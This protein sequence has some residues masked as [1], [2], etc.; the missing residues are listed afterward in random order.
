LTFEKG[1]INLYEWI[2][3]KLKLTGLLQK[4]HLKRLEELMVKP[5]V[6]QHDK[7][8]SKKKKAP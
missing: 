2:P 6:V 4:Q 3:V 7:P 1:E 5:S 8:S